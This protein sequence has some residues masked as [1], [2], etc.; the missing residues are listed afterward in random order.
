MLYGT[1]TKDGTT[2]EFKNLSDCS[3]LKRKFV[4]VDSSILAPL[5]IHSVLTCL[6]YK[7]TKTETEGER[8]LK[9]FRQCCELSLHDT[10]TFDK[11]FPPIWHIVKEFSWVKQK[12]PDLYLIDSKQMFLQNLTRGFEYY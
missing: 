7:K 12:Y 1:D 5:D 9:Y 10:N 3:F 11:Y 8:L 6:F 4:N 2:Y